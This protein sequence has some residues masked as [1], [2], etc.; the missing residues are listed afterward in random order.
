MPFRS[1][2]PWVETATRE[3]NPLAARIE[4]LHATILTTGDPVIIRRELDALARFAERKFA[5]GEAAEPYAPGTP[6]DRA[7]RRD[8]EAY[9][10]RLDGFR[11]TLAAHPDTDDLGRLY[12]F[13]SE[14]L[15]GALWED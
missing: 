15:I 4:S 10:R 6:S 12:D 14:W 1:E 13:L 8:H 3:R 2:S 7:R 5:A 9:L 11:Q